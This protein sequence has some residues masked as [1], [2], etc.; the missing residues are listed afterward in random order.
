M[1]SP[2]EAAVHDAKAALI[3]MCAATSPV[4][5]KA[6]CGWSDRSK[7]GVSAGAHAVVEA[8]AERVAPKVTA[9]SRRVARAAL[10]GRSQLGSRGRAWDKP[11]RCDRVAA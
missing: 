2:V 9:C 4:T 3:E 8:G 11:A 7:P 1:A 5:T 6:C 10:H